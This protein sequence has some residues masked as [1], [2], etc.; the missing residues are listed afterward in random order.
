[1]LLELIRLCFKDVRPPDFKEETYTQ[2]EV[3]LC[4]LF[5]NLSMPSLVQYQQ[6]VLQICNQMITVKRQITPILSDILFELINQ[7]EVT[8]KL[9]NARTFTMFMSHGASYLTQH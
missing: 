4:I 6:E 2:V 3:V 9:L 1:M 5:E 8:G 7:A